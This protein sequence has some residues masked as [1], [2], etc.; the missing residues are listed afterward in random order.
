MK[1][2]MT[3]ITLVSTVSAFAQPFDISPF[4]N[5]NDLIWDDRF[6]SH[7]EKFFGDKRDTYFWENGTIAE[8]FQVGLGGPPNDVVLVA[9]KTFIVS[10]C[11]LHSC[12]EKSAYIANKKYE[13]FAVLAYLCTDE[14]GKTDRC[15]AGQLVIFYR[16][17]EAKEALEEYL[18][19]WKNKHAPTAK[20]IYRKT[21]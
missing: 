18:I 8:Q 9:E 2:L 4:N 20:V 11:R 13:L 1:W 15:Y 3:L 5:A 6:S 10:A 14:N 7:I 19:D 12:D 16:N 17:E 21:I